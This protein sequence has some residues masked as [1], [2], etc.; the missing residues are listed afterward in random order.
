M[1]NR[2]SFAQYLNVLNNRGYVLNCVADFAQAGDM[3]SALLS[4]I[5]LYLN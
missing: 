4:Y 1:R 5:Y 3:A 2:L